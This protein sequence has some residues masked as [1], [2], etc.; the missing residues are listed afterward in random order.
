[1]ALARRRAF[2]R[3]LVVPVVAA[4]AA[5]GLP[6]TPA[7]AQ[8]GTL[9]GATDKLVGVAVTPQWLNN[10]QYAQIAGQ[11]FSSVT[12]E[13]HMKWSELQPS[14]GNFTFGN[15]NQIIN[16]AQQNNQ[17]V[18]GH[19]LIWHTGQGVPGWVQGQTG[20]QL[21]QT[22]RT[23]ITTVMQELS[24]VSQWDVVNEVIDDNAQIRQSH[25]LNH[26]D[27]QGYIAD[28]FRTARAADSS[29]T[30]CI[31]DYN[32][33]NVNAKSNAYYDLVQDLMSQ[34]VPIDCFGTQ[35]HL[36]LGEGLG[37]M[38]Q[39]MQRFANLG[40]EV[41]ITELDIRIQM[42]ASPQE[43][44]QQGQ[45]SLVSWLSR[46]SSS[47]APSRSSSSNRQC[48]MRAAWHKPCLMRSDGSLAHGEC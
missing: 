2:R 6:A 9:R 14:P 48:A 29:K 13:N 27:G 37:S 32:V 43:L 3:W 35:T 18:Y 4:V 30:L 25:W 16:F 31:N 1:M 24:A 12:A 15:A 40:L 10:S 38:Q 44:E 46:S 22:M 23:H 39:N 47:L 28:A 33:H 5:L 11:Q 34:G 17:N 41:W 42:P 20:T 19:A 36:V 8:P 21:Q 7:Q 45:Q 26:P